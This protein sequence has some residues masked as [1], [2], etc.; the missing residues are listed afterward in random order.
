MKTLIESQLINALKKR[1]S[2]TTEIINNEYETSLV[3]NSILSGEVIFQHKTDL[4]PLI[5]IITE[6]IKEEKPCK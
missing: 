2:I 6:R 1:F 5:E 3:V 4:N